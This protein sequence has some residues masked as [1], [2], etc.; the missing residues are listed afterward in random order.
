M[1]SHLPE[2]VFSHVPKCAGM[3]V[4][5]AVGGLAHAQRIEQHWGWQTVQRFYPDE[6]AAYTRFAVHRSSDVAGGCDAASL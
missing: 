6:Y 1:F 5:L 4:E 3:S 2:L